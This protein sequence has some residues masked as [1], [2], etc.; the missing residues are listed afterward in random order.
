MAARSR[1]PFRGLQ[2]Q[3][4]Q[5]LRS[6]RLPAAE[7][8]AQCWRVQPAKQPAQRGGDRS[9]FPWDERRMMHVVAGSQGRERTLR[10]AGREETLWLEPLAC[11]LNPNA[12]QRYGNPEHPSCILTAAVTSQSPHPTLTCS[13]FKPAVWS[14]SGKCGTRRFLAVSQ[15][16]VLATTWRE[17]LQGL[18][19]TYELGCRG[20]HVQVYKEAGKEAK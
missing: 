17:R 16:G 7:I 15:T 12:H 11:R 13:L 9:R 14:Q 6:W 8:A 19:I 18:G 20:K 4:H 5:Q 2:I 10:L 3:P 1:T